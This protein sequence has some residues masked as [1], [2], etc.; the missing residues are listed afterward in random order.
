M[1]SVLSYF[2]G[3]WQELAKVSWPNREQTLRLTLA[4]LI[5]STV[6]A[7]IIGLLDFGLTELVKR[8]LLKE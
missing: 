6:L 3:S 2:K 7:V 5:F 4:V 1:P 8:G